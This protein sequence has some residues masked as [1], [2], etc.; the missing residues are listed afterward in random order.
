V[1]PEDYIR[2][3]NAAQALAQTAEEY[4]DRTVMPK[5]SDLRPATFE[6]LRPGIVI[7]YFDPEPFWQEVVQVRTDYEPVQFI[8][9]SGNLY[10]LRDAYV[11]K[12]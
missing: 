5:Q 9:R 8:A 4:R 2:L 7:Y 11:R 12:T 6:D 1:T 10:K 3:R